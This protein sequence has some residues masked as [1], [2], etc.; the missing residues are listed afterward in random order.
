MAVHDNDDHTQSADEEMRQRH[1]RWAKQVAA[2]EDIGPQSSQSA[3][4]ET[5]QQ[6]NLNQTA[7]SGQEHAPNHQ[8]NEQVKD[9]G[10]S[11][12]LQSPWQ[13]PTIRNG[14]VPM[15]AQPENSIPT[16]TPLSPPLSASH[17]Q[18]TQQ[19][20]HSQTTGSESKSPQ[21]YR[22][23]RID[24]VS[25]LLRNR[26]QKITNETNSALLLDTHTG[27]V[28]HKVVDA[29]SAPLAT[30]YRMAYDAEVSK[31]EIKR[32]FDHFDQLSLS[33]QTKVFFGRAGYNPLSRQR[34]IDAAPGRCLR[35]DN[36]TL[37]YQVDKG[38]PRIRP[39]QSCPL[40]EAPH[41]GNLHP[42]LVNALFDCTALCRESNLL[43]IAWMILSWMPDRK[44]V[45]LE[46]LGEPS[47][48]LEDAHTLVK[49][50][51]DPAQ[52]AFRNDLPS[53]VKQ[54]NDL[55]LKHYLLS[56]NQ[57]E[58]LTPTQQDHIFSLMRGKQ[59]Q[60]QWKDK[61]VAA[62]ITAQCPVMLNSTESVATTP[63]LA[64]ATLSIEVEEDN[65]QPAMPGQMSAMEPAIVAGLLMIFGHVNA[66]WEAVEYDKEFDH[67]GDLADLCRVGVLVAECLHQDTDAFWQQFWVNQQGRRE[68]ELEESPVASAVARALADEPS[69]VL[70]LSV[71]EWKE[72]LERYRPQKEDS[73]EK[74]PSE[75]EASTD[76]WPAN[77]RGLG[78]RFKQIKPLLRDVG[79]S[80]TSSGRRGP[81]RRWRAE[82]TTTPFLNE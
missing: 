2:G 29:I 69:G 16:S 51:V 45:M 12:Q 31:S 61:K 79:I 58:T 43:L 17:Q 82:K 40:R 14:N 67:C 70:D 65:L 68:F 71:T 4:S 50:V 78:S 66:R 73:S 35:F 28:M 3:P 26:Y 49:N 24:R 13:Q 10:P 37:F 23:R 8:M 21:K 39:T 25:D 19:Q 15:T 22:Q 5:S 27:E 48:A 77:T 62:D 36:Y 60:W 18:P 7:I 57:V 54:F 33:W 52:E 64:D 42:G 76:M 9:W 44:Q 30:Q 38:L 6:P 63:K 41:I 80:L 46:L 74:R 53:N 20:D 32:A 75:K 1:I 47:A 59:I 81:R 56:F 34:F 55:A 72:L 11:T